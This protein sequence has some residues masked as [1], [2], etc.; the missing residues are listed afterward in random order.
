MINLDRVIQPPERLEI[1]P[2]E[3]VIFL[4]GPIQGTSDWQKEA[5]EIIHWGNPE[6]WIFNPRRDIPFAENDQ[7]EY[8]R[9]VRWE[10]FYRDLISHRRTGVNLFWL[11]R[12]RWH[13]HERPY[14]QTTR[15]ETGVSLMEKKYAG[16]KIVFGAEKGYSG[17]K[18][19]DE[20]FKFYCLEVVIHD[21]L[22]ATCNEALKLLKS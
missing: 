22:V 17:V 21:N 3:P 8:Q 4:N 5:I 2:N 15:V 1:P 6:I 18:Y 16:A 12:E 13:D 11:A 14:A 19:L 10:L 7:K 9:Q 20:M